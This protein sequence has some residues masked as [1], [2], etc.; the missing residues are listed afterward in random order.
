MCSGIYGIKIEGIEATE[1]TDSIS[2]VIYRGIA[3]VCVITR[4]DKFAPRSDEDIEI[5]D[6]EFENICVSER[7]RRYPSSLG[8]GCFTEVEGETG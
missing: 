8:T 6:V 1:K 4:V 3:P 7:N 5:V 2:L